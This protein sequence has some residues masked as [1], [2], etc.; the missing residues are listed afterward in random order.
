MFKGTSTAL[1]L[2]IASVESCIS[3]AQKTMS[4]QRSFCDNSADLS[5]HAK[6]STSFSCYFLDLSVFFWT[7]ALCSWRRSD[8]ATLNEMSRG[9][10]EKKVFRYEEST[11]PYSRVLSIDLQLPG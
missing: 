10:A 7:D 11:M 6:S 1:T 8:I 2:H 9:P 4:S 3:L 5:K